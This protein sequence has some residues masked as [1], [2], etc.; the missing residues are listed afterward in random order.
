MIALRPGGT[1]GQHVLLGSSEHCVGL[2]DQDTLAA[3]PSATVCEPVLASDAV[4]H[5][6]LRE[7]GCKKMC[8]MG[9]VVF[10][11]VLRVHREVHRQVMRAVRL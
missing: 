1:T 6:A 10:S 5:H 7:G 11:P 9:N 3:A 8:S 4:G 2:A